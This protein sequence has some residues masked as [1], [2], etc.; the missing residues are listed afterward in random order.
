MNCNPHKTYTPH[1]QLIVNRNPIFKLHAYDD[2][3]VMFCATSSAAVVCMDSQLTA[4]KRIHKFD[5]HV[6]AMHVARTQSG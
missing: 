3:T 2:H 4:I 1:K 6:L 5:Q